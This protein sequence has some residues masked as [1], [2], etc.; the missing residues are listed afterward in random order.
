MNMQAN[1]GQTS[2]NEALEQFLTWL[3]FR[4]VRPATIAA[5]SQKLNQFFNVME[6]Q[7]LDQITAVLVGRWLE[8]MREQSVLYVEHPNR[9]PV[10]RRLS[11][12]T[13]RERLKT[14]RYFIRVCVKLGLLAADPLA[15]LPAPKFEKV[16]VK[17]RTMREETVRSLLDVATHPRDLAL[18]AFMAD[19]GVR[20]GEAVSLKAADLD[21]ATL[22]AVIDGKSSVRRVTFSK[23]CARLIASWL[24][25]H[26]VPKKQ[27]VYVF[28]G[29]GNRSRGKQLSENAVRILFRQLGEK[30]GAAGPLN[31]HALRHLVGQTWTDRANPRLAQEKLGHSDIK[32]TL[33]FYYHP[34]FEQLSDTTETLSLVGS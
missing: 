14:I 16:R 28:V 22:S 5:H 33:T 31:P 34:D 19:T 32:T 11:P 15:S 29:L 7:Q 30:S 3:R 2:S 4:G 12:V 20:V 6:V 10:A 9:D 18:I 24:D 17:E 25:V 23:N 26:I 27:R 13:I 21:L 8:L 1:I